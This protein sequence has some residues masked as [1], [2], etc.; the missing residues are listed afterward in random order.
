VQGSKKTPGGGVSSPDSRAKM[1]K[2]LLAFRTIG[3]KGSEATVYDQ[4]KIPLFGER[5]D[6]VPELKGK[7]KPKG[8]LQTRGTEW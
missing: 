1:S 4:F 2:Y 6:T 3:Q 7:T 8:Y 5:W